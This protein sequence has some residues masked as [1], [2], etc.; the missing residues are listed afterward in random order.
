M[1]MELKPLGNRCNLDCTYCYQEPMRKAGNVSVSKTYDLDMMMDMA[2]AYEHPTYYTLF[3]GEA[4]LVPKKDLEKVFKR[5]YEKYGQAAIQSNGALIDDDH[6]RMFKKYRVSV[7]ISIDGANDLNS[8]RVSKS[9]KFTTDELTQKTMDNIV[10]LL[11]ENVQVGVIITVHRLNGTKDKLPRLFSFMRWLGD[12][13]LKGGNLHMLE[14]DSEIVAE[15][16]MLTPEQN[17][18][19]F[20]ELAKFFDL[21]ENKDLHWHPFTE[22]EEMQEDGEGNSCIWKS[23]DPMNTQSVY[24]IEGNGQK[25]NCGMVNKEGIEWTKAEDIDSGHNDINYMRDHLLYQ[26]PDEYG[27]CKGCPY[28]LLCN[29]YCPGSSID[30]DWR[31]KTMH[32]SSLKKLFKYYE[33][34]LESQGKVPF[35][36]RPDRTVLEEMY[37]NDLNQ[38]PHTRKS[39]VGLKTMKPIR[40]KVK[41]GK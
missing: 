35:S 20:L 2:D 34:K 36:K 26:T 38:N 11:N 15:N 3:G 5:S 7:G 39:L 23:C 4:L 12:L 6:I 13:G 21:P 16:Y 17:E 8:L 9:G 29:G 19:A 18:H 31:N 33:E 14:V 25:S 10:K 1:T 37:F 41:V 24:G 27:G 22:M 30:G 28:F 40:A 32:C